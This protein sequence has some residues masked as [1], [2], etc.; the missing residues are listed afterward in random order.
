MP[1]VNM[2]KLSDTMEEG[3]VLEWKKRD[4]D[5]V[6][7]GEALAEIETDK[8]SFEIEAEADGVLKIVVEQGKSVPVGGLIGR[9]AEAGDAP[10]G[11]AA[12]KAEPDEEAEP[13][14]DAGRAAASAPAEPAD[15]TP[16]DEA[17]AAP[18]ETAPE[19]AREAP[20][21]DSEGSEGKAAASDGGRIKASPLARRLAEENGIDLSSLRGTGPGGRIV[22]EDVLAAGQGRRAAP[23]A[24][25][26]AAAAPTSG[27]DVRVEQPSRMQAAIARR[28]A[29]SKTTVP[30][31]YVTVEAR[32]DEAVRM[33]RQLKETLPGAEQLTVTDMVVRAS[34]MAVP[35]VPS[36]NMSWVDGHFEVKR[37]VNIGIAVA[38]E[39][40]LVVPVLKDA[41]GKDLVQVSIE[42]REL[43]ERARAGK[44]SQGDLTGGTF[45]VSN[46]GMFGVDEFSAIVN[47]PEAAILAV[48]ALKD[49]PVVVDGRIEAA[50]VMRMTISA[51]HRVLYGAD[52][53]RLLAEVK[54]LLENPV[55]LVLPA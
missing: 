25:R 38:L 11:E 39:Q 21:G 35:R 47:P 55:A 4:G 1:D 18:P 30:H 40:G 36:A 9:I 28:M 12:K 37:S 22:K 54:R 17:S 42:S 34:A 27:P 16:H 32:M 10:A 29:G 52:A 24:A 50:K 26:A 53:A 48:G 43:V 2:P 15:G 41:G 49:A 3:S 33:R 20:R 51:D 45:T 31:F 14:K 13:P 5:E 23:P 46:L 7:R 6:R 8:A 44:L 19:R